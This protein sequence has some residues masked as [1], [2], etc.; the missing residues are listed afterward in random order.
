M[1]NKH[2]A[3]K[4]LLSVSSPPLLNADIHFD[5][6]LIAAPAHF[7]N[8][9]ALMLA[10][11]NGF[12]A[13]EAAL[14]VFPVRTIPIS[15][16]LI[17]WNGAELWRSEYGNLTEGCT[18]FAEDVFGDQFCFAEDA[19]MVFDPET[20]ERTFIASSLDEW[21]DRV[22]ADFEMLTG[23]RLAQQWQRSFGKL[24]GRDRLVP[25]MPFVAGGAL[26]LSNLIAMDAAK[27]MRVRGNLA[28]QIHDLPD[29][30]P[31]RFEIGQ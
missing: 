26:E 19:I 18:F 29:G 1:N 13:F 21:A 7:A 16:G 28:Q 5:P 2:G 17:E 20:S 3:I 15:Y 8:D 30:S 25:K 9:L 27:G 23:H 24:A 14:R 6:E 12:F 10:D 31:I 22:L 11:R 4:R